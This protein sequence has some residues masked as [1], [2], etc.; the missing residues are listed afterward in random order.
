MFAFATHGLFSGKAIE[1]IKKSRLDKVVVTNTVPFR[2]ESVDKIVILSVGT[3][4][5]ESIRRITM[6]ES[7]TEVFLK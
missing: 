4:I 7:L 3:L 5:A 1:N 6:N 2:G